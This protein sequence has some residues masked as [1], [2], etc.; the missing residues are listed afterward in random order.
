MDRLAPSTLSRELREGRSSDL[1]RRRW[2]IGL[3]LAGAAIGGVV[4]LYQVGIIK[5]LPDILPGGIFDAEKVDAS[6]YAYKRM[7]MPDA[8]M[9]IMTY[10]T[11]AA[12]ASAGGAERATR[13]PALALAFAAK[14]WYDFATCLRLGQEEWADNKALCSWCQL[15]TLIS[16]L[17]AAL[18][19]P[20]AV[21][22]GQTLLLAG[23]DK[24]ANV[25]G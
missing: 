22:A 16:A 20:E 19:L 14:A 11:T 13:Q 4:T 6:D 1:N 18:S 7:Q 23:A 21:R 9:M 24:G 2:A 5:R 17:T 12:L 8:A 15:A 25:T 10:A 3:S